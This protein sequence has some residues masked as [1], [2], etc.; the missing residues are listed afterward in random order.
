MHVGPEGKSYPFRSGPVGSVDRIRLRRVVD[1]MYQF[2]GFPAFT[3][4][5]MLTGG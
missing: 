5:S 4:D 2:I 1:V 3:I